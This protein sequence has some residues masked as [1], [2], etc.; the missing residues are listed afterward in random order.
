MN[1]TRRCSPL[2]VL[3]VLT[4]ACLWA[5]VRAVAQGPDP[6]RH[7]LSVDIGARS[8]GVDDE[9]ASPARYTGGAPIVGA[10]YLYRP[11]AWRMGVS[12]SWSTPRLE[13][14]GVDDP[15]MFEDALTVALDAWAARRVWRSGNGRWAAFIGPGLAVDMGLRRHELG[16]DAQQRYD[17]GFVGL[18]AVGLLEWS[19]AWG[20]RLV[21]RVMAPVLGLAARTS[22]TGLAS[23]GPEITVALPPT[24]L[25]LRHRLAY[26]YPVGDRLA[27]SVHHEGSFLRHTEP[28]ELAVA[29]Q[30]LGVGLQL[31]W[32]RP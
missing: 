4:A 29:W 15:A 25:L 8:E 24:F 10:A 26:V 5:P 32:G 2:A 9:L 16:D 11:P 17:N 14:T 3:A 28:L 30:R 7:G 19:P 31:R 21:G 13:P 23:E 22:Y 20:G 12:G 18:E 6:G 1:E 27:L